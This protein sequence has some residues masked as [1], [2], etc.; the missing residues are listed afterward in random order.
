MERSPRCRQS[1]WLVVGLLWAVALL[2]YLDRQL[3]TTMGAPIKAQ[4]QIADARFGLFSSVFL[5]VYAL[6]SPLAGYLADRCGRKRMI[7][8]SLLVW[9]AATI[10]TGFARSFHELLLARAIM[11]ISEACYIPAAVALIVDY[12][13]GPTRSR[14]T[15]WHLSGAYAGSVLGGLGGWMALRWGWR[16]GFQV[17]GAV[18]VAYALVL[19]RFLPQAPAQEPPTVDT[20]HPDSAAAPPHAFGALLASRSFLLLLLVNALVGA[21]F[22][23]IKNWLPTF[24]NTE[25]QFDLTA[26]GIYGAMAFNAAAFVGM[27]GAST[28]SDRWSRRTARA[29]FWVP[30][31]GFCIAAPCFFGVGHATAVPVILAAVLVVGASQGFLDANLMPALCTLSAPRHRATGYGLLNFVST[32]VGGAMTYVGG[33][34]KDAHV[35]L[36]TTFQFAA[37]LILLAGLLLWVVRPGL[38]AAPTAVPSANPAR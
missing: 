34:L 29:R 21:A 18:G 5:W 27:L 20:P 37:V 11:G 23:T 38:V 4:L 13:R 7:I 36:G 28:L 15:G 31:I 9:S 8:L 2:N 14:A 26:A 12:H 30:A 6:A 16:T 19:L 10:L 24:F 3:I 35:P 32:L 17:F 22:W 33:W 1:A 25:L